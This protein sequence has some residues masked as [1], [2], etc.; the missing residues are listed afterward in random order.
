MTSG[1][2]AQ[3]IEPLKWNRIRIISSP[4]IRYSLILLAVGYLLWSTGSLELDWSR[5]RNGLPRAANMF[6]RM[7]PPDFSRWELLV[8]GILELRVVFRAHTQ[9]LGQL[10][11]PLREIIVVLE[12]FDYLILVYF[13]HPFIS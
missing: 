1:P 12:Q 2:E 9:R 6:A 11:Q 4:A 3:T 7:V 10:R 5:I 8:K 13:R